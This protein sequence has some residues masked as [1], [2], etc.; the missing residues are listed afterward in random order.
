VETIPDLMKK[1]KSLCISGYAYSQ[2]LF[3]PTMNL[4]ISETLEVNTLNTTGTMLKND[5]AVPKV[6]AII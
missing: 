2:I 3:F 4:V 6:F 1:C 5:K